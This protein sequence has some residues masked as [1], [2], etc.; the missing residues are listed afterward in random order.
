[1]CSKLEL[2]QEQN[3]RLPRHHLISLDPNMSKVEIEV[4]FAR[5]A[6]YVAFIASHGKLLCCNNMRPSYRSEDY[7]TGVPPV[8]NGFTASIWNNEIDS[9]HPANSLDMRDEILRSQYIT[10]VISPSVTPPLRSYLIQGPDGVGWM[11]VYCGNG[12]H[13][14]PSLHTSMSYLVDMFQD[15]VVED[16]KFRCGINH[17]QLWMCYI[18]KKREGA[19]LG[20]NPNALGV[21]ELLQ[22]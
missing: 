9:L 17:E 7:P 1:M 20:T 4:E 2:S 12:K 11:E 15:C 13:S 21:R 8:L 14:L 6:P 10:K 16:M 22:D 19:R 3:S 18:Y 5:V